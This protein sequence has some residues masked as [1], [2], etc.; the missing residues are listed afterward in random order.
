MPAMSQR[1]SPQGCRALKDAGYV[2][3][4]NLF[5]Y[6]FD[7]RQDFASHA[8]QAPLEALIK[9][10][11]AQTGYTPVMICH[12]M[13][14][15]VVRSYLERDPFSRV[16]SIKSFIALCVPFKGTAAPITQ[17][18]IHGYNL[19]QPQPMLANRSVKQV[20]D[21]CPASYA[22]QALPPRYLSESGRCGV[23]LREVDVPNMTYDQ[24]LQGIRQRG[25]AESSGGE[26]AEFAA[27]ANA[28]RSL[29]DLP[30]PA[31]VDSIEGVEGE[32][33]GER[34]TCTGTDCEVQVEVHEGERENE[35]EVHEVQIEAEAEEEREMETDG[36]GA[37]LES[38]SDLRSSVRVLRILEELKEEEDSAL[39]QAEC[40]LSNCERADREG[41]GD[42][43][44]E[45]MAVHLSATPSR[46]KKA[47]KW[48]LPSITPKGGKG[49]K[50]RERE[51]D[52]KGRPRGYSVAE[53]KPGLVS[54]FSQF[55]TS[56]NAS[57]H[58][59]GTVSR[60]GGK[61]RSLSV[62][63]GLRSPSASSQPISRDEEV[64]AL[65]ELTTEPVHAPWLKDRLLAMAYNRAVPTPPESEVSTPNVTGAHPLMGD[66]TPFETE[67]SL[68]PM[69]PIPEGVSAP[70]SV[71]V[72]EAPS[73]SSSRPPSPRDRQQRKSLKEYLA[74]LG[75]AAQGIGHAAQGAIKPKDQRERDEVVMGRKAPT[76][77]MQQ[78]GPKWEYHQG[79]V[80]PM[81]GDQRWVSFSF[82]AKPPSDYGDGLDVS[83]FLHTHEGTRDE[84]GNPIRPDETLDSPHAETGFTVAVTGQGVEAQIEAEGEGEGERESTPC[85]KASY[86]CQINHINHYSHNYD[87]VQTRVMADMIPVVHSA[88][89]AKVES[90][91]DAHPDP[92]NAVYTEAVCALLDQDRLAGLCKTVETETVARRVRVPPSPFSGRE[93]RERERELAREQQGEETDIRTRLTVPLDLTEPCVDAPTPVVRK[94]TFEVITPAKEEEREKEREKD[95]E[96]R[97]HQ[98]MS[99]LPTLS[100]ALNL[101]LRVVTGNNPRQEVDHGLEAP[102]RSHTRRHISELVNGICAT[103]EIE[104]LCGFRA[105]LWERAASFG[106]VLS[107]PLLRQA[108]AANPGTT[109]YSVVGN[110]HSTWRDVVYPVPVR[111]FSCGKY[112]PRDIFSQKPIHTLADDGDG[113]VSSASAAGDELIAAERVF[114]PFQHKQMLDRP[115]CHRNVIRFMRQIDE[116]AQPVNRTPRHHVRQESLI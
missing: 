3:G 115:E 72:S 57:K 63:R 58:G 95:K 17:S 52:K 32:R 80:P 40:Y 106:H 96:K 107:R 84:E 5:G 2:P 91:S 11:T 69:P 78:L 113:T 77:I 43:E 53:D 100:D 104:S 38:R 86:T 4:V 24:W 31:P 102:F 90:T 7:W 79:E 16:P 18:L 81:E 89:Q 27:R 13:G 83:A 22:L 70:V 26:S 36:V 6:P 93:Q 60:H 48:K 42:R 101:G 65:T 97:P 54:R 110:R 45:D 94:D 19:M 20:Q 111:R 30:T 50:K 99:H 37:N 59:S 21:R 35:M 82:D 47:K 14:G 73:P 1:T 71:N 29:P 85:V 39:S 92:T 116:T 68:P 44:G 10:V 64:K 114:L 56:T 55:V 109:F 41:E 76:A 87:R 74:G 23:Y 108:F 51:R 33:E 9:R 61:G 46:S 67:G 105:D 103:E 98:H 62:P 75:Q 34:A 49:E 15:M 8:V 88:L 12:S 25:G 28:P 112:C 66:G